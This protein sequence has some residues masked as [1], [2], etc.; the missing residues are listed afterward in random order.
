MN[1]LIYRGELRSYVEDSTSQL[2]EKYME[3]TLEEDERIIIRAQLE[4]LDN[5]KR[6]CDK[7]GRY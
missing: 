3:E 4:V 1:K 2:R 7:R 6:I 5:I